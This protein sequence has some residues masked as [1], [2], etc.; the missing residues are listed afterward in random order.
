MLDGYLHGRCDSS[1]KQRI[2][3]HGG[4]VEVDPRTGMS[5]RS[6]GA[7]ETVGTVG[8]VNAVCG[9][10][11]GKPAV[12]RTDGTA[13]GSF[14]TFTAVRAGRAAHAPSA[15]RSHRALTAVGT[16]VAVSTVCAGE[17][18]RESGGG[19]NEI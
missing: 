3:V 15:H 5:A 10:R 1:S 8:T 9:W 12:T 13:D 16:V 11:T 19:G 2:K 4:G 14:C 7:L 6:I 17:T 18:C